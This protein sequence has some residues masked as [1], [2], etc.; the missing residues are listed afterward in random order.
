MGR[1]RY[2]SLIVF[3]NYLIEL[4]ERRGGPEVTFAEW[5]DKHREIT[6]LLSRRSLD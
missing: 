4:Q 1:Y 5:L 2:G 6:N 3:A